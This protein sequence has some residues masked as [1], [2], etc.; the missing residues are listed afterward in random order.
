MSEDRDILLLESV[1][2]DIIEL[3]WKT[4][5]YNDAED[6][7][8]YSDGKRKKHSRTEDEIEQINSELSGLK[9]D[10]I[11]EIV[12]D[13]TANGINSMEQITKSHEK[14]REICYEHFGEYRRH[15]WNVVK[16]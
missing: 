2:K 5:F 13:L 15:F 4:E 12:E 9:N 16:S 8:L 3:I 14:V 1:A 6:Y 11:E 10:L 7:I